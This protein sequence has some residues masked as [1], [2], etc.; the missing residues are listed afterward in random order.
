MSEI[1]VVT[2]HRQK[3]LTDT[4]LEMLSK[5]RQL[6]DQTGN[7]L[8]AAVIGKDANKY[9]ARTANWADT[10][11]VLEDDTSEESLAEPCQHIVSWLIKERK[12]G[13]VLIGHSLFG[14]EL[15]PALAIEAG[16]PL[17]TDC[18]GIR[19]ENGTIRIRRA[20]Y[21]GKIEAEYSFSPSETVLVTGRPGQF[22]IEEAQRKG[23]I[24]EPDFPSQKELDYKIF[25]GYIEP[26]AGEVDI[27]K[28]G[29]LVSVG[30]G[31]KDKENIKM[32]QDIAEALGGALACSRPVVDYGWLPPERQVG[33]SCKTVKP[34]L[35][36]AHG[37][38]GAFPHMAGMR[39]SETII[40][41]NR[42]PK[43]PIFKAADYGIV[44]DLAKV[45]PAL[46]EVLQDR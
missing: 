18:T 45:I 27:T 46:I 12:P 24:E 21:N 10:V 13:L 7:K 22:P 26:Q 41:I 42:D 35:D 2:E 20:I 32:A 37:L 40:A 11:L 9:A 33:L 6:A 34:R 29:I 23:A 15:A 28:A 5:G 38:S 44:D 4:S 8:V 16:V 1:L 17:A 31:I 19:L 39:N 43:A 14:M 30:R 25:E 36:L 3:Q